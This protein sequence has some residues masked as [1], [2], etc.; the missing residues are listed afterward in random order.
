GPPGSFDFLLLLMADI[1][2][3]IAELQNKVFGHQMLPSGEE[4]P[5]DPE[6]WRESQ[7]TVDLGT[8]KLGPEKEPRKETEVNGPGVLRGAKAGYK[9]RYWRKRGPRTE[10]IISLVLVFE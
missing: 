4:F 1:R 6:S 10:S 5:V 3:D 2:N 7:D 9:R 8:T